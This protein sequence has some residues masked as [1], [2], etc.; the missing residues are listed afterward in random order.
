MS[1]LLKMA[2]LHCLPCWHL[3]FVKPIMATYL[4]LEKLQTRPFN[5]TNNHFHSPKKTVFE[6]LNPICQV[7]IKPHCHK[8]KWLFSLR[9]PHMLLD[10]LLTFPFIM[11][12]HVYVNDQLTRNVS[13]WVECLL[14]MHEVFPGFGHSNTWS[15]VI[16]D[17]CNPNNWEME[18]VGSEIK[19][20]LWQH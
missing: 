20:Y 2:V 1:M 4:L 7:Y 6:F 11:E 9:K 8:Q 19:G 5:L 17:I 16:V 15:G 14:S 10:M 18:A 12:H 3:Y 13:Q